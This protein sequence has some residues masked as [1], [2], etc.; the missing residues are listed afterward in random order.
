[1]EMKKKVAVLGSTGMLGHRVC[2]ELA[3]HL[4]VIAFTRQHNDNLTHFSEKYGFQIH[5]TQKTLQDL[6]KLISQQNISTVINCI[7]TIKQLKSE[8][9]ATMVEVNSALPHKLSHLCQNHGVEFIHFSTDCVFSGQT[10][11]YKETDFCDATDIYGLS[12]RLGEMFEWGMTLRTS[13]IGREI[14]NHLSLLEWA[15]SNPN[16][17]TVSGYQNAIFSGLPTKILAQLVSH[18]IT[19][20]KVNHGLYHVST[21]AINKHDLLYLVSQNWNKNWRILPEEEPRINR[22]LNSDNFENNIS[23]DYEKS[24]EKLM[25]ELMVDDSIYQRLI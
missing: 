7:G 14:R 21:C 13:I 19:D 2:C 10:G 4:D 20:R 15:L 16:D 23:I 17:A 22:S 12:K 6:K 8:A 24:W 18:L 11:N 25:N 9:D 5:S 1:M 3:D